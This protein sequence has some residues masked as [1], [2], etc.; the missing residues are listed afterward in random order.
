MGV[1]KNA[2]SLPEAKEVERVYLTKRKY[3]HPPSVRKDRRHRG[4][5]FLQL[6]NLITLISCLEA[7]KLK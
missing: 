6:N 3:F 4:N 2:R 1:R 5:S 7:R